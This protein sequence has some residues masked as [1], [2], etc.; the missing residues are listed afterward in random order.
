MF[1]K[2]NIETELQPT[3]EARLSRRWATG[4]RGW[5]DLDESKL[6]DYRLRLSRR[7]H[8][9]TWS[10]EYGFVGERIGLRVDINGLTGN[11]APHAQESDLDRLLQQSQPTLAAGTEHK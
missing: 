7:S 9:L 3:L 2:V 10:L 8:C 1:D 11:T 4:A 5:L 6:R